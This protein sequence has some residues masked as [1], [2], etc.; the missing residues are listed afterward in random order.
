MCVDTFHV[1]TGYLKHWTFNN[2]FLN[3]F[4]NLGPQSFIKEKMHLLPMMLYLLKFR[5]GTVFGF[6]L[7]N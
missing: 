1:L 5:V 3:Y 4:I 7:G 2:F 6:I